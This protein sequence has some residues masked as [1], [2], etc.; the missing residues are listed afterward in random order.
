MIPCYKPSIVVTWCTLHNRI[1]IS[2]WNDP[3]FRKHE[4]ENLSIQGEKEST[5]SI[6]HSIDLSNETI[7]AM[8]DCINQNCSSDVGKLYQCQSMTCIVFNYKYFSILQLYTRIYIYLLTSS[9]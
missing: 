7:T 1:R 3:L 8:T 4:V 5:C 2:I 6:S 9:H